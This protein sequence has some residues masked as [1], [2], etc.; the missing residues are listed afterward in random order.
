MWEVLRLNPTWYI[1]VSFYF[2]FYLCWSCVLCAQCCHCLLIVHS[3]LPLRFFLAFDLLTNM[4]TSG[5]YCVT[6]FCKT[7]GAIK[8]GQSRDNGNI[9]HT[10]HRTNTKPQGRSRMDNQQTM[11]TV[12]NVAIV[13]WLS[14]LDCPC[15]F[16]LVLSL[17]CPM[18]PLSHNQETMATL[19]TQ[20]T[21]PTQNHRGNQEWT[22]KR[23]WQHWVHKTQDQHKTTGVIKNGKSRDNGNIGHTRHST[24]TKPQGQW[25]M[26]VAI[27]SWLSILDC[28]CDFVLVLCLVCPMLPLSLDCPFLIAPVVLCWSCVLCAQCCHCL[29]IG[30]TRHRTNTKPQGQWRMDN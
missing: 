19:G 20:E 15:G 3:W 4:M 2:V 13:S 25:R 22:I 24:N 11:A 12:P 6:R 10:R 29:Y 7:T 23:Q 9:G 16:V 1:A 18:L 27:V 5:S 21:G 17:V 28:P 26:D 14:I 8:N 30:Y